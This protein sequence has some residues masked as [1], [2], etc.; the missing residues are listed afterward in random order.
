MG[1]A[2]ARGKMAVREG[3]EGGGDPLT[4]MWDG[5]LKPALRLLAISPPLIFEIGFDL[6]D[7]ALRN[8]L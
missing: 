8:A 7:S 3:A 2:G 4:V 6:Q 5:G 1:D